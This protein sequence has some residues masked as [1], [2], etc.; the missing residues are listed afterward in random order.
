MSKDWLDDIDEEET[1]TATEAEDAQPEPEPPAQAEDTADDAAA[2]EGEEPEQA[3]EEAGEEIPPDQ[4]AED[5]QKTVPLA[6]LMQ[7]REKRDKLLEERTQQLTQQIEELKRQSQKQEPETEQSPP[8][9]VDDPDGWRQWNQ[10]TVEQLAFNERLN[11][12]E[13]LAREKHGDEAVDAAVEWAKTEAQKRPALAQEIQSARNPYG[14]LMELH[15][16]SQFLSEVGDDPDA[17]KQKLREELLKEL[18]TRQK[19]APEAEDKPEPPKSLAKG[20]AGQ[21]EPEMESEEEFFASVF[22]K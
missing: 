2:K 13:L 15:R 14:K 12:T 16:Q 10:Q 17:Y 5:E 11:T 21:T 22:K 4:P 3:S 9:P 18:Q 7:E 19:P 20:G 8:D 1:E 6:V